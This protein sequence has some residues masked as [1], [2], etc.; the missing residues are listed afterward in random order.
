MA[1]KD[2]AID[3][4]KER[5]SEGKEGFVTKAELEAERKAADERIERFEKQLADFKSAGILH[6]EYRDDENGR[7]K[8]NVCRALYGEIFRT[9]RGVWPKGRDG[10][11]AREY[12]VAL[13]Y[14]EK[15]LGSAGDTSG[16]FLIPEEWE[17]EVVPTLKAQSIV[18]AMGPTVRETRRDVL[19]VPAFDAKKTFAWVTENT[20][21]SEQTPTTR[22]IVLTPKKVI[23]LSAVSTEWLE[24][25]DAESNDALRQ[26]LFESLAEF[27]D[28][29]LLE[30]SG[31]NRPTGLRSISGISEVAGI[32]GIVYDNLTNGEFQLKNAD[33]RPPFAWLMHPRTER[34]LKNVKD[35][36]GLPLFLV[37]PNFSNVLQPLGHP[38]F[39][40]TQISVD[41]GVSSDETYILLVKP[42]EVIVA[43]RRGITVAV[44]EH[45]GFSAD[46]IQIRITARFDLNLK[47]VE[48]SVALT[49]IT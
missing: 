34:D 10:A 20:S 24:D 42:S 37:H 48:S 21:A 40:S 28:A 8:V 43:R 44:S 2:S 9:K 22:N 1:L 3:E 23:G 46:Q 12:K 49:G 4:V 47:H 25:A 13:D 27:L 30:G 16:G 45:A 38:V 11:E 7:P 5:L 32:G 39:T 35:S 31:A 33:V 36:N 26:E 29:A 14:V 19:N 17:A 18:F 15:A 41:E 6:A